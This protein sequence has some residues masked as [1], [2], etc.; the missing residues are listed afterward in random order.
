MKI[1]VTIIACLFLLGCKEDKCTRN[2]ANTK[3]WQEAFDHCMDKAAAVSKSGT[4]DNSYDTVSECQTY[5][6]RVD[7]AK[8]KEEINH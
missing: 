6:W 5:A 1:T 2:I 7:T 4:H 8:C 3:N